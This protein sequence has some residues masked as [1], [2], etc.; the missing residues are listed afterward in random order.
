MNFS[1]NKNM[2][3]V[4]EIKSLRRSTM[5]DGQGNVFQVRMSIF[6]RNPVPLFFTAARET[7]LQVE[8]KITKGTKSIDLSNGE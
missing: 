1:T 4:S 7:F 2:Q 6:A 8:M 5:S 3:F